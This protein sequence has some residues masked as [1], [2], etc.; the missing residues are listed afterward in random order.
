VL[1]TARRALTVVLSEF[2]HAQIPS[3]LHQLKSY[4]IPIGPGAHLLAGVDHIRIDWQALIPQV[5]PILVRVAQDG[6]QQ[7]IAQ[8]RRYR[9][10]KAEQPLD[11]ITTL[12]N[13]R[14]EDWAEAR[15]AE[16]VGMKIVA[17]HLM[18]NPDPKWAITESTRDAIRELV[19]EAIDEGWS[20]D[21]LAERL[22]LSEAFGSH[23]SEMIA[24]TET[25][26]ADVQGNLEGYKTMGVEQKESILSDLHDDA[27]TC[28]CPDN[29]D[30]GP[31]PID[32]EFPSGDDGPPY[33]PNCECDVLPVL[34]DEADVADRSEE[35]LV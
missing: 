4:M 6:A 28:D 32:D 33:H 35:S 9:A 18:Q 25:A 20:N 31:I 15:A 5:T 26:K 13:T 11:A 17:G 1:T 10:R 2:L 16:M 22:D 30:A 34:D 12:A 3:I 29:A 7:A 24:R 27:D 19:Q 23:R 21:T 8:I 14:A